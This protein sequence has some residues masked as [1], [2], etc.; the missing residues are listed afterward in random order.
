MPMLNVMP[1]VTSLL[2]QDRVNVY[3]REEIVNNYGEGTKNEVPSLNLPA[4]VWCSGQNKLDRRPEAQS[5]TKDIE[6]ICRFA[7]RAASKDDGKTFQADL[8]EWTGTR[9]TVTK[10][11]DY[12]QYGA[13]FTHAQ[14]TAQPV[15]QRGAK[16]K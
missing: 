4:V 13:G 2:M 5:T 15:L 14:A 12:S 16:T 7:L 3:R 8:I 9:Y 1:A 11:D 10:V 6:V